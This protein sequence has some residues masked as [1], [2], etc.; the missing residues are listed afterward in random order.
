M[1][2]FERLLMDFV[3]PSVPLGGT[4]PKKLNRKAFIEMLE[5]QTR[6]TRR[7][8]W[9][10][11]VLSI[12]VCLATAAVVLRQSVAPVV[13]LPASGIA[14][15]TMLWRVER[16]WRESERFS[17][18]LQM[19]RFEKDEASLRRLLGRILSSL[20]PGTQSSDQA[21]PST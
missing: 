6:R 14:L 19:A 3:A 11:T 17:M 5:Q 21:D 9:L 10:W 1:T 20:F 12:G 8:A 13:A 2:E 4:A 15:A 16:I 18:A 7:R